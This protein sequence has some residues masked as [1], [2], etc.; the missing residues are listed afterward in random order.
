MSQPAT[1]FNEIVVTP[2]RLTS[3]ASVVSGALFTAGLFTAIAFVPKESSPDGVP[4]FEEL[5]A[6]AA[7]VS[8][9]PPPEETIEKPLE[10]P[11]GELVLLGEE[12]TDSPVKLPA[13]PVPVDVPLQTAAVPRFDFA[14]T[15]FQPASMNPEFEARRVYEK[16]E[17]DQPPVAVYKEAPDLPSDVI[18]RMKKLEATFVFVVGLDGSASRIRVLD[19]SNNPTVDRLSIEALQQWK[20]TPAIKRGKT[21]RCWIHQRLIF[22][23][24]ATSRFS[25]Q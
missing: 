14:P 3:V 20:F 11:G 4:Q 13:A 2:G 25:V 21:V 7:P 24:P 10:V 22:K 5:R 12:R 23:L 1:S 16:S 15:A 6:V 19:S 8:P 9:P 17:V 18:K